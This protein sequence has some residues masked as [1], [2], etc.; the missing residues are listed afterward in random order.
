MGLCALVGAS[1]FALEH[2]RSQDFDCIV[3]V[4]G[5]YRHLTRIDVRPDV[6][7]GDFDSLGYVPEHPRLLRFSPQKDKTDME[8]ALEWAWDAGYDRILV[9]G[10]LGGRLDLS[11]A[12]F[13]LL[14]R[15]VRAG[16][17]VFAIGAETVVTALDFGSINR[18]SFSAAASGT[19][20]VFSVGGKASMVEETGLAYELR[21]ATLIDTEPLGVSNEFIGAPASISVGEGSLLVFFPLA[22]WTALL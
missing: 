20:S 2:F 13:Q 9:Y 1:G 14:V 15:F 12:L 17:S 22:A 10:G 19:V 11:Y 18:L 6:V 4:D 8:L 21:G 16:L 7:L 5:G 3:A